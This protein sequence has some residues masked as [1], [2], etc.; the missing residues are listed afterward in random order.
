MSIQLDRAGAI[1]QPFLESTQP[2]KGSQALQGK[3]AGEGV[4]VS[5]NSASA[6]QDSLEEMSMVANQFKDK[7]LDKRKVKSGSEMTDRIM[8]RIQKIQ[9]IQSTQAFKDVVSKFSQQA[10][11]NPQN[12]LKQAEEF[13]DDP[14]EQYAM[15]DFAAE[16]FA[17]LGDD[18]KAEQIKAVRD[19]IKDRQPTLINVGF[20]VSE[21]A[22]EVIKR[23]GITAG[24]RQ[25]R[26][27]LADFVDESSPAFE[28]AAGEKS[29]DHVQDF[30]TL[31]SSF[32]HISKTF[33]MN[34]FE[35]GRQLILELLATNQLAQKIEVTPEWV[36]AIGQ[37][38]K[39]LKITGAVHDDCCDAEDQV[40]RTY[41]DETVK[42][43]ILIESILEV[44]EQ[45]WVTEGDFDKIPP[46]M[47]IKHLPAEIL[48]LTSVH[49]IVRSIPEEVFSNDETKQNV[50]A[51]ISESLDG[52]IEDE[53]SQEWLDSDEE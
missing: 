43:D 45:Q 12:I 23:E 16:Y 22:A 24:L 37:D 17:E 30:K 14:L 28:E 35:K 38:M 41:T 18:E 8:E 25:V 46:A 1:Q 3:L 32:R 50:I 53:E 13:T 52:K 9:S 31:L 15:L 26:E 48:V 6:L 4:S 47:N 27:N 10:T 33:G 29:V 20:N 19:G 42:R 5:S 34:E 2:K 44:V 7:S 39:T 36:H 21:K 49:A 11:L 51:A 40:E